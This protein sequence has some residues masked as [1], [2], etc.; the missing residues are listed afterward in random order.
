VSALVAL[1][2][3]ALSGY[4]EYRAGLPE[5]DFERLFWGGGHVLQFVHTITAAG[6]WLY[7]ARIYTGCEAADVRERTILYLFYLLFVLAAPLLY[8]F[9]DTSGPGYREAFTFLMRWGLGPSTVVFIGLVTILLAGRR[10]LFSGGPGLSALVLSMAL[11]I[12][13]G[14]VSLGIR[15]I[16][17]II[18][19]HYHS[20]IAGITIAFMGLFYELVP[21][22]RRP[23][24]SRRV[25]S[26]QPWLY[27]AGVVLFV[28]GFYVAGAHGAMRKTYGGAQA[29]GGVWKTAGLALMGFGGVVSILGGA[30]FVINALATLLG[31]RSPLKMDE[32]LRA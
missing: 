23:L 11:F 1:L 22:I 8:L 27:F 31:R 3:F 13:G 10:G 5:V 9:Y 12:L 14:F 26:L 2:C 30:A 17:T 19:A 6:V 29:P 4:S 15:G 32:N 18:P 21:F 28:A 24:Y 16:N 20:E 25:A 7:L